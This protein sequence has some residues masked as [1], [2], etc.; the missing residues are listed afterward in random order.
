MEQLTACAQ[1][2]VDELQRRGVSDPSRIAVAGHSYGVWGRLGGVLAVGQ[3]GLC[4]E[5]R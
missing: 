1:A 2:A 3:A 5:I 4:I